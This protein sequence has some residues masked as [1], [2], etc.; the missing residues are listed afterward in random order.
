M[1]EA[2]LHGD[3]S[4][5]YLILLIIILKFIRNNE[6]INLIFVGIKYTSNIKLVIGRYK[7]DISYSWTYD[8]FEWCD[9]CAFC[10]IG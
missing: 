10:M 4:L 6:W 9:A 2:Y 7:V 8:I 1:N 3:I 5:P